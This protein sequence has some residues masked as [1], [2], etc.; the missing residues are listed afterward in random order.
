VRICIMNCRLSGHL[1]MI[2]KGSI[3]GVSFVMIPRILYVKASATII[4]ST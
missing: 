3:A 1:G 4:M 2:N